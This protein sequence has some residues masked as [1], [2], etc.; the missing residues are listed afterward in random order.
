MSPIYLRGTLPRRA[1]VEQAEDGAANGTGAASAEPLAGRPGRAR[2][3]PTRHTSAAPQYPA[4][5]RNFIMAGPT[6]AW[7]SLQCIP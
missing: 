6:Y 4:T 2:R 7:L 1:D 5:P 3:P